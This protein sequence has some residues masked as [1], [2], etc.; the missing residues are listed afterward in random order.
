MVSGLQEPQAELKAD[1]RLTG[2]QIID[3]QLQDILS[4]LIR[5]YVLPW[6]ALIILNNNHY[7][8]LANNYSPQLFK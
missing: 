2:S 4:Y 1:R 8:F 3:D 5:D 6:Y 7:D